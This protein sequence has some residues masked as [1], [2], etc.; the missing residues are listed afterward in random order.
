MQTPY[1]LEL[2]KAT[3]FNALHT[4]AKA[5]QAVASQAAPT[6]SNFNVCTSITVSLANTGTGSVQ[7]LIQ[8]NLRNGASGAGTI[9]WSVTM[10]LPATAGECRTETISGWWEGSP[11]TAMTLESSAAPASETAASVSMT[12]LVCSTQGGV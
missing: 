7:T 11:L 3:P 5:T 4:P 8:F 2:T 10:A 12:G 9:I 1:G 6:K